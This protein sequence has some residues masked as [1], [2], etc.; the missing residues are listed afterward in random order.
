L[1]GTLLAWAAPQ[2]II[3][4]PLPHNDQ[5]DDSQ[6]GKSHYINPQQLRG[7]LRLHTN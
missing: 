5:D 1:F 2:L 6:A 4:Q 3:Q 7:V